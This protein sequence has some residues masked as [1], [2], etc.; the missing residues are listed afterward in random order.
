VEEARWM[1][2]FLDKDSDGLIDL[3][4]F[5]LGRYIHSVLMTYAPLYLLNYRIVTMFSISISMNIDENEQSR[6]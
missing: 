6:Q 5:V 4:E 2:A 1:F 3:E